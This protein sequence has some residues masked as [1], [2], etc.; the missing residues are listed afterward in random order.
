MSHLEVTKIH[1][2]E[3]GLNRSPQVNVNIINQLLTNCQ[4]YT[5]LTL[6]W[7]GCLKPY[8]LYVT[9]HIVYRP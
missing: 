3:K 2:V 4:V 8:L 7:K 6:P 5:S 9:M 1:I